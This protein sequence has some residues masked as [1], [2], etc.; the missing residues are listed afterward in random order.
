MNVVV[1]VLASDGRLDALGHLGGTFDASALELTGLLLET[2][3]DG[4][5][6]TVTVLA[7]LDRGHVVDVLLR[8]DFLVLHRLDRGVVVV[9]VNLTVDGG[10]HILVTGLHDLLL[11]DGGSDLLVHGGVCVISVLDPQSWSAGRVAIPW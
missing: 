7:V 6:V 3:L 11:H 2:G 5:G 9:L 4:G 1:D 8:E 10:L